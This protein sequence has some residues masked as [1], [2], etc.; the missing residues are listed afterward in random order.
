MITKIVA[1]LKTGTIKNVVPFGSLNNPAPP[2]I[3]VKSEKDPLGRGR[4]YR[5]FTHMQPGQNIF[6]EDYV[7]GPVTNLLSNFST[8]DRHGNHNKVLP[9]YEYT[10][11]TTNNDDGTISMEMRF[12]VPQVFF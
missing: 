3:V 5:I 9:E 2:Y 4:L 12:L 8:D 6:L 11:I 10:D 1:R 7:F